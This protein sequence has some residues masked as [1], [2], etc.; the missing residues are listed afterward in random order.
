MIFTSSYYTKPLTCVHE[1]KAHGL[2]WVGA[3]DRHG[4]RKGSICDAQGP[5]P[6]IWNTLKPV[7]RQIRLTHCAYESIAISRNSDFYAND[8][9][10]LAHAKGATESNLHTLSS[11]HMM[12]MCTNP[13][14]VI[15]RYL[16]MQPTVTFLYFTGY[17]KIQS[18]TNW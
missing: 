4:Q 18:D 7:F 15:S 5:Y 9:I 10:I 8:T 14:S 2:Q 13:T 17:S 1:Q 6:W 16:G 11:C 3:V 12:A